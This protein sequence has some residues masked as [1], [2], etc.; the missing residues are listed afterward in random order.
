M[1]AQASAKSDGG[2]KSKLS[3]FF[4]FFVAFLPWIV[5]WT[6]VGNVPFR[7]A[8]LVAFS[9]SVS[10]AGLSFLHGQRPKVLEIGNTVVFAVLTV[11]MFASGDHF[12][13]RWI[14]PLSNAGLF[15]IAFVS[16]LIGRPFVL[17][18]ARDSV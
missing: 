4:G 10:V 6:L 7:V 8:V 2:A 17:D 16:V 9:L 12:L 5:Y 11:L 15:A 3:S 18:Y 14:Q 13:E 1:S